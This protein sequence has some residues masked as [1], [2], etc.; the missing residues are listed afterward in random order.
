M[1]K[2]D[3]KIKQLEHNIDSFDSSKLKLDIS[4]K[5]VN[6]TIVNSLRKVCTDQI[7]IYAFH[8]GKIKILRNSSVY[9]R[10]EMEIRLSQLPI[11]RVLP[12]PVFLPL[13]YY[14]NVNFADLKLERHLADTT[15][16]ECYINI[17]NKGPEKVLYV[18]ANEHMRI[19]VNNKVIDN[20]IMY[21][22]IEPI[23][24]IQLRVGEEFECSMKGVLGVGE[25]NAIFN[26]SN[27]YYEELDQNHYEFIIESNGQ[28]DEYELLRRGITIIIEKLNI[29]K[30]NIQELQYNSITTENNSIKIIMTN[31]D[32]TCGG[33]LNYILQGMDEV[34]FSGLSQPNLM[35]KNIALTC[36]FAKGYKTEIILA[37]GIDKT[38]E[39]FEHLGKIIEEIKK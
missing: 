24:L 16:I 3:F 1:T 21:K 9:D 26:A 28:M 31:E 20:N 29:I 22:G 35:E 30:K 11:K 33:P 4:G 25:I 32:Y 37:K 14:K 15:D 18:T 19:S 2:W 12:G 27:S 17:K 10:T 34:I 38:V 5:D 39:M 6:Y 13:K 36:V 23:T 8:R 7:P